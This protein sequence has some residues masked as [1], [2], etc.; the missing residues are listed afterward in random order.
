MIGYMTVGTNNLDKAAAFYD[1]LL[2]A[3]GASRVMEQE[4]YFIVWGTSMEATGFSVIKPIN[5]EPATAGNGTMVALACQTPD[6]VNAIYDKAIEL[7]GSDEGAPGFRPAQA[8]SGFYGGY[9][10]DL[11]GNKLN[12]FCM[13]PD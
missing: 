8:T 7:G 11:D 6:Q 12:A 2:E 4:D 13:V 5:Q 9:F 3:L 10:R 1:S